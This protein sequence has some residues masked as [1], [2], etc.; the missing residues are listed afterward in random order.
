[1]T[2]LVLDDGRAVSVATGGRNPGKAKADGPLVVLLHGAGMDRTVWSMQTRWLAHHGCP[3]VAI[4]LPGHGAS[5]EP[6]CASVVE[7]ATWLAE[8]VAATGRPV[9]LVGH[10]MGS[11]VAIECAARVAVASLTLVGTAAAMPVHPALLEAAQ[12]D[13]VHAA[14]LMSG[15]GFAPARRT[16]PNPS[17]GASM[18]GGTLGLVAQSA[19]GV[20]FNDLSMCAEY[21]DATTTIGSLDLPVTFLLGELDRMT[22]VRA[23]QPLIDAAAGSHVI[24]VPGA[25][26]MLP[27]EAPAATRQAIAEAVSSVDD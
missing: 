3:A 24:V 5:S 8:V 9:H 14:R 22:P 1:M 13:R 27:V 10:S 19:P 21:E 12:S 15:W 11:F 16:G 4:D 25:G 20:L 2:T 18:V 23:A 26:H 7:Y 17:P 6:E